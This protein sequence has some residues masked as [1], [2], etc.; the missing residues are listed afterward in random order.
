MSVLKLDK[1]KY[2]KNVETLNMEKK[3]FGFS[4]AK[5]D[6]GIISKLDLLQKKE[7][8]LDMEKMVVASKTDC[9]INQI[10]LFKALAGK[11]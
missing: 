9:M 2:D 3:D 5:Y 1:E 7:T 6:E 11:V 8:L 10:S 4:Q